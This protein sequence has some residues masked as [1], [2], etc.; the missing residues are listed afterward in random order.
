MPLRRHTSKRLGLAVLVGLAALA[1]ARA[2]APAALPLAEAASAALDTR[3]TAVAESRLIARMLLPEEHAGGSM[4]G[5]AGEE[6]EDKEAEDPNAARDYRAKFLRDEFGHIPADGMSRAVTQIARMQQGQKRAG[7]ISAAGISPGQ[8][9]W[10][11]PG[12]IGGRVRAL[13]VHTSH[14]GR[15]YAGTGESFEADNPAESKSELNDSRDVMRGD[16]IWVSDDSGLSWS[17]LPSTAYAANGGFNYVN[18]I[19]VLTPTAGSV[20]PTLLAGTSTGL[21]YSQNNG[22]GWARAEG[23]SAD[24]TASIARRTAA[25]P[26]K[27]PRACRPIPA[28]SRSRMRLQIRSRSMRRSTTP[29]C[30]TPPLVPRPTGWANSGRAPMEASPSRR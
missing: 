14:P 2:S 4:Y 20:T 6:G 30:P 7:R 5:E 3:D 22:A 1:P 26:G 28:G 24:I 10:D 21:L 13:A 23:P 16:G 9:T 17:Q 8:W 27:R 11:G 18:R 19:A 12:N 25:R 29:P 15:I